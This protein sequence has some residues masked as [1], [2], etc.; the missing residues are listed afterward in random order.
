VRGLA[1]ATGEEGLGI[2]LGR[3]GV[4]LEPVPA[5]S[6]NIKLTTPDDWATAQAIEQGLRPV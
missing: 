4:A 2:I 5:P 6:W 1:G 3:G